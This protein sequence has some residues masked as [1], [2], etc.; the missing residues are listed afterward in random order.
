MREVL[1]A[2]L[3]LHIELEVVVAVTDGEVSGVVVLDL[4]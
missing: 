1:N 4:S 3:D 2:A